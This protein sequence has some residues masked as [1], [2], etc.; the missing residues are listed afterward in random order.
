[1]PDSAIKPRPRKRSGAEAK[2]KAEARTKGSEGA[3]Q[4]LNAQKVWSPIDLKMLTRDVDA[5]FG[6][7]DV[8]PDKA[9]TALVAVLR[10]ALQDGRAAV[11]ARLLQHTEECAETSPCWGTDAAR[12]LSLL[13]D[14]I[15]SELYRVA[16]EH[17]HSEKSSDEPIA[18]VAIGGYGRG[19]MAPGSDVD[20]LFLLP[21]A[22]NRRA[23]AMV[24]WMLYVLWDLKLKVGHA[25][26]SVRECS[27]LSREDATIRTSLLEARCICG[28]CDLADELVRR[29]HADLQ[30]TEAERFVADKLAERDARHKRQGDTRYKVEP[31]IK[32]GKGG[33]RDLHALFWI[34]KALFGVR[35]NEDLLASGVFEPDEFAMFVA[36]EDF[37]WAVRCHMHFLRGKAEEKLSFDLQPEVARRMGFKGAVNDRDDGLAPVE[38]FMKRYFTVA[39]DVGDL[40]RILCADLEE[41]H[42]KAPSGVVGG[43]MRRLTDPFRRRKLPGA[44]DFEVVAGR[45]ALANEDGFERDPVNLI[46]LFHLA[47]INELELHPDTLKR[48]HR[49]L[50]LIDDE[51]RAN[52]EANRLFLAI[53]SAIRDPEQTLK[54]MNEAGVLGRF[55]PAFGRIVA[56]MQFSMYHHYTVDEHLIQTVGVLAEIARGEGAQSHP[57]ASRLLPEIE[58]YAVL[59]VACFLHDIAKGRPEDH[60]VAGA[61]EAR[62]LCPRLGLSQRQT[63]TVA[64]LIE[65]H[66]TLSMVS[67]TRDLSDRKTVSD[68]AARVQSVERLRMLTILTVCDIR[69]VGPGVWNGWKGQLIRTL[70]G[71]AEL[72]LTGGHAAGSAPERERQARNELVEALLQQ[73]WAL[74]EA[75][76]H[77]ALHYRPYLLST[78][79]DDKLW[80]AAMMRG[81]SRD[82]FVT[83]MRSGAFEAA[84]RIAF[85]CNDHPRLL[86]ILAGACAAAG[87]NIVDAQISTLSDG[88]A[89]DVITLNRAFGGDADEERRA[90][91]IVQLVEAVLKGERRL[92]KLIEERE[93][94]ERTRGGDRLE[95]FDV[96]PRVEVSNDLSERFTVIEVEGL[97]RPGL[98]SEIAAELSALNLNIASAHVTTFGEKVIDA[99]YVTDLMGG[100][101][102]GDMR[103]WRIRERLL[104]VLRDEDDR[105]GELR[106][107]QTAAEIAKGGAI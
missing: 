19:R 3:G 75:A 62:S 67:Q 9:R 18:V 63:E 68:F 88:R 21:A 105:G 102:A 7:Y 17:V 65:E 45:I 15:V 30:G 100:R 70:H 64:W 34:V 59:S 79:L 48:V 20:L 55:V 8:D 49:S 81:R 77:A 95:A 37:Q 97:D 82:E 92:P 44:P 5:A 58:D 103:R 89:L 33:Q 36:A 74:D 91:R 78:S 61:E 24:E 76:S 94:S 29:V 104:A 16:D 12:S 27:D 73:D 41:R 39:K 14:A 22:E 99:F 53:L 47:D 25:T 87:S 93:R 26:R 52:E 31:N 85:V 80:L 66:L 46:R 86:A 10:D 35:N 13:V 98:L 90:G 60:S 1:M 54:R 57:L 72:V 71:E 42:L 51:L 69:A 106:P 107:K 38:R 2:T 11:E 40:T 50:D 101:I 4:A 84:T 56:M 43:I 83:N 23:T 96:V 32:E 6:S 28:D